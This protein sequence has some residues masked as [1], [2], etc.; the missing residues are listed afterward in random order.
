MSFFFDPKYQSSATNSVKKLQNEAVNQTVNKTLSSFKNSFSS[1]MKIPGFSKT[2]TPAGPTSFTNE[3]GNVN[4]IS[5]LGTIYSRLAYMNEHQFLLYYSLIFGP[6][7]SDKMMKEIN[8]QVNGSGINSIN[9]DQQMFK[10]SKQV[11]YATDNNNKEKLKTYESDDGTLRLQFLPLAKKINQ[12]IGEERSDNGD[13]NCEL[14]PKIP[15][16]AKPNPNL[17]FTGIS[18]SNYGTIYV[19]GDRRMPNIITVIFRGTY[20][21]KSAASYLSPFSIVP[22]FTANI[23]QYKEKYLFG[24]FKILMD[25]IHVLVDNIIYIANQINPTAGPDKISIFTTGHSLGGALSTIFAYLWVAHIKKTLTLTDTKHSLL[26]KNIC[27]V[28]VGSPRI[29]DTELANIFCC[30]ISNQSSNNAISDSEK[31]KGNVKVITDELV[32]NGILGRILFYRVTSYYDP[33]P[34]LPKQSTYTHPCSNTEITGSIPRIN[35]TSDCYVQIVNSVSDRCGMKSRPDKI[36]SESKPAITVDYNL[37]LNCLNSKEKRKASKFYSPKLL[38][39]FGYHTMYLGIIFISALDLK[40]FATSVFS[41]KEIKRTPKP[42]K[43]TVCRLIMYPNPK[44]PKNTNTAGVVYYNLVKLRG[45]GIGSKDDDDDEEKTEE[46][47]KN[48]T[49]KKM[50][51]YEKLKLMATSPNPIPVSEDTGVSYKTFKQLYDQCSNYNILAENPK[52]DYENGLKEITSS[53]Y[54]PK[55]SQKTL[56]N[57]LAKDITNNPMSK[58]KPI[59]K[60]IVPVNKVPTQ[61]SILAQG[62]SRK[63]NKNTIKK[64]MKNKNGSKKY[65][66]KINKKTRKYKS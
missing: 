48:S 42:N 34:G 38:N 44:T 37:P 60:N 40:V 30:L 13:K 50:G 57:E 41:S 26:N 22:I 66:R 27:C 63:Y 35:I 36:G 43:D 8:A 55:F 52:I 25:V 51:N 1:S 10:L 7:V 20:S 33:V 28:S 32:K 29:M 21:G 61:S 53:F 65:K 31:I 11:E 62:G 3:Y 18:T 54:D 15:R 49:Q 17:V 45:D 23:G 24:I 4:F 6:I 14:F 59:N 5:F 12:A 64:Y 56:S 58:L 47:T 2:T 16:E 46:Q 39:A 9:N 19:V